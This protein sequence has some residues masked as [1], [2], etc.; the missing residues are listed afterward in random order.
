MCRSIENMS[1]WMMVARSSS[2]SSWMLV[3]AFS[4][5]SSLSSTPV[6][7][8]PKSFAAMITVLPSPAPMSK[9]FSFCFSCASCSMWRTTGIGDATNGAMNILCAS[10][11]V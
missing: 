2:L 7:L 6:A 4:I 10:G 11:W 8:A 3:R 9:K 5:K 1:L